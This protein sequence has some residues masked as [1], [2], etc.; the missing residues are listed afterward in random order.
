MNWTLFYNK[1]KH[2]YMDIKWRNVDK[3]DILESPISRLRKF[4]LLLYGQRILGLKRQPPSDGTGGCG[5][6]WQLQSQAL[7]KFLKPI[8][9]SLLYLWTGLS[10]TLDH[11]WAELCSQHSLNVVWSW[12]MGSLHFVLFLVQ[13][14]ENNIITLWN[15]I[16]T[17]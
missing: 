12:T 5:Q 8:H 14:S 15:N 4:Y 13:R 17:N 1:R 7:C 6:W 9:S 16:I 3:A 10:L 11:T 2:C